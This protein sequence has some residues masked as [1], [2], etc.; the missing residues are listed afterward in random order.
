[1]NTFNIIKY[2]DLPKWPQMVI[3]GE[4]VTLDQAAEILVRTS[5]FYFHSNDPQFEDELYSILD[6]AMGFNFDIN[7]YQGTTFTKE[8]ELIFDRLERLKEDNRLNQIL[9]LYYLENE[10]FVNSWVGGPKGWVNW[11][12]EVGC[13]NYNI[14]KWPSA[15]QVEQEWSYIAKAF[16]YLDLRCQLMS[17]ETCEDNVPLIEYVIKE[18]EVKAAIPK[19][20]IVSNVPYVDSADSLLGNTNNPNRER[21]CTLKQFQEAIDLV[22]NKQKEK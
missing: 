4:P 21:G 7:D 9:D 3:R 8:R 5:S 12:G 1:M 11:D 16:P 18:G 13:C 19:E 20:K 6:N 15:L 2:P 22:L 14:G 17:G 10:R